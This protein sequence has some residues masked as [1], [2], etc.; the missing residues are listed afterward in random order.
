M[1]PWEMRQRFS[2]IEVP[3]GGGPTDPHFASVS[4]LLHFDGADGSTTFTDSGPHGHAFTPIGSGTS[5]IST[6]RSKF[7]GA[8]GLFGGGGNISAA[9]HASLGF[10]TGDFCLEG[11]IYFDSPSGVPRM[12]GNLAGG[13]WATNR[14]VIASISNGIQLYVYN[15]N[16][17]SPLISSTVTGISGWRHMAIARNASAWRLFIDGALDASGTWSG[18]LDGGGAHS[19]HIAS[20]GTP[21]EAFLGSLDDVRIT[22]GV[23][24]YTADFTPPSDPFP[25]SSKTGRR[26]S[27]GKCCDGAATHALLRVELVEALP[28]LAQEARHGM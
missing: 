26:R 21:G 16:A 28:L 19:L 1:K 23:A 9:A 20:S 24:R 27:T 8:S 22:K 17:G 2:A 3:G 11:W 25:D 10:D 14:W 6:A 5:I 7:G 13:G 18:S 12:M 4:A 15:Y